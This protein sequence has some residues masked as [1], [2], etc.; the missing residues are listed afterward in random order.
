MYLN[1]LAL[2]PL[3]TNCYIVHSNN[4]AIIFDP[5]GDGDKLVNW[6]DENNMSPVAVLLTHAHFDHIGAVDHIRDY[7]SIPVYLHKEEADWLED[8]SLNGSSL[9]QDSK[10]KSRPADY[11]LHIGKND[12]APFTFEV[13]YT[14]GHSPGSVSFVFHEGKMVIGGD[15]LFRGGIGRTDLPGGNTQVLI[16]S[17]TTELLTLDES[18]A[19]YPGHGPETTI[20]M[21][22]E[23]NPF[24]Q[25]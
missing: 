25:N 16:D 14:P 10:I 21:E 4:E 18:Y 24:L 13:R 19:V 23:T 12:I 1:K 11:F 17:I 8:P 9:F 2:G 3:G 5:G 22:V 15:A 7:F 20:G 6:L